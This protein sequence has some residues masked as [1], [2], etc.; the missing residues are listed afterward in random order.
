VYKNAEEIISI[1]GVEIYLLIPFFYE[2]T[3]KLTSL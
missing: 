1:L 3:L 2:D